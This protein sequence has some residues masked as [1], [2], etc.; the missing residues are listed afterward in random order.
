MFFFFIAARGASARLG[1]ALRKE[2]NAAGLWLR[3]RYG[4]RP[5]ELR[6]QRTHSAAERERE[7]ASERTG[8][9][10]PGQGL[11]AKHCLAAGAG[12]GRSGREQEEA[13]ALGKNCCRMRAQHNAEGY[14]YL[15]RPTRN[16]EPPPA[17]AAAEGRQRQ[18]IDK[19]YGTR[20]LKIV[21]PRR[22]QSSRGRGRGTCLVKS[23]WSDGSSVK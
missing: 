7:R 2:L 16:K 10:R 8:L 12:K 1:C 14:I 4:T 19:I 15:M 22:A 9:S 5:A 17:A 6:I 20:Q 11:K 23:T 18:R 13:A 21:A 3:S